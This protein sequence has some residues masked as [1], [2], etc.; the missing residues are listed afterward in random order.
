MGDCT[1]VPCSCT[2]CQAEDILGIN[3]TEGLKSLYYIAGAFEKNATLEEAIDFLK[4]EP[5]YTE[6][7][8]KPY[9][10]SWTKGRLSALESLIEYREK[11]FSG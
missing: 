11:Y 4:T 10:G 3:T 1:K 7:W 8:H 6:D 5:E 9:I 2:K